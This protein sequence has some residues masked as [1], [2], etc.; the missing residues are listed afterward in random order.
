MK[1][2]W[3][4]EQNTEIIF[5]RIYEKKPRRHSCHV[6]LLKNVLLEFT[7]TTKT[8]NIAARMSTVIESLPQQPTQNSIKRT[9]DLLKSTPQTIDADVQVAC[10]LRDYQRLSFCALK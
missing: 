6:F 2:K 5:P 10:C 3:A 8:T 7:T 4:T 1:T 9:T